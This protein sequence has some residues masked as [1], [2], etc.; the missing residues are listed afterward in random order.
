MSIAGESSDVLFSV[1]VFLIFSYWPL[2]IGRYNVRRLNLKLILRFYVYAAIICALG[3]IVQMLIY[4]IFNIE[5]GKIDFYFQRTGFGFLWLDYSFLSLFL[6]SV[7]PISWRLK[8]GIIGALIVIILIVGSLSTSARTGI[9]SLIIS[10]LIFFIKDITKSTVYGKMN[11]KSF[12]VGLIAVL[13]IIILPIIW[14]SISDRELTLSSS[15]RF[16]GYLRG[17]MI[18]LESPYFGLLYDTNFYAN[19]YGAIPHNAF[20][21]MFTFGGVIGG[22]SFILWLLFV[23]FEVKKCNYDMKISF[24]SIFI[25]IQFIPSF[26]SAY[27]IAFFISMIHLS[28]LEKNNEK[29]YFIT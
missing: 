23:T 21:Y 6:A 26:F 12:Y 28:I 11:K 18:Y 20:I 3:V 27:F 2:Y 8:N 1:I 29:K 10:F 7:V 4:R 19:M 25:G 9:V 15:G 17:I 5:F 14:S 13:I 24:L 16:D 22:F